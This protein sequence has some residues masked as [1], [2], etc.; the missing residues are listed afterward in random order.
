[1]GSA[2]DTPDS[3]VT[4]TTTSGASS[5]FGH[6]LRDRRASP[7]HKQ[8][9]RTQ[10]TPWAPGHAS[11]PLE[12]VLEDLSG[13]GAAV[14][15]DEPCPTGMRHLLLVPRGAG[16]RPLIREYTV[17]RCDQRP[18]GKYTIGLELIDQTLCGAAGVSASSSLSSAAERPA[19]GG[20]NQLKLIMLAFAL[21]CLLVALFMPL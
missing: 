15:S 18:D 5:P 6:P 1:M 9:I 7:R 17:V 13:A 16:E 10:I 2:Q 21:I 14:V 11:V 4:T 8:M 12:V 20:G 3:P 19:A